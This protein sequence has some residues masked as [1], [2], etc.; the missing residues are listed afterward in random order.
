MLPDR[1]VAS[2]MQGACQ[3]EHE[4][5]I[6]RH[7]QNYDTM[8]ARANNMRKSHLVLLLPYHNVSSAVQEHEVAAHCYTSNMFI[9][10]G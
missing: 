10:L 3:A 1:A 7:A 9:C 4:E 8:Q 5:A 2:V 6:G